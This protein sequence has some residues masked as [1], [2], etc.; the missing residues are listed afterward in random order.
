MIVCAYFALLSLIAVSVV[1][2]N[3]AELINDAVADKH[4]NILMRGLGLKKNV[5][6]DFSFFLQNP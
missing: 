4:Y 2:C 3:I 1:L 6:T 5:N